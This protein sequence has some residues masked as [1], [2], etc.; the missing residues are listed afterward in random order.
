MTVKEAYERLGGNYDDMT[1]QFGE[2][3][4]LRL[5]GILLKDSSYTD[6]CTALDRQDYDTAFRGAHTL[7]GIALNMCLPPLAK[8]A[9]VLAEALRSRQQNDDIQPSLVGLG[10]AYQ[11]M[12]TTFSELILTSGGGI[13]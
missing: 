6:I 13:R 4:L 12:Y 5:I 1:Y 8:S 11:D 7:K 10:H 2:R 3:M 9:S